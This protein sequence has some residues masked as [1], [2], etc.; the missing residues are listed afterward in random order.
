MPR[1]SPY[2][3]KLDFEWIGRRAF[4]ALRPIRFLPKISFFL[5]MEL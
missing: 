5:P 2:R 4:Y 3:R 1:L